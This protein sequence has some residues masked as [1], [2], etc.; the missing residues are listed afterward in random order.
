MHI[1][2]INSNNKA[3][4]AD[5]E[6]IDKSTGEYK[7]PMMRWPLR[8]AA[9]TNEIGEALRPIIGGYATL[10]WVPALMYIGADIYDKYK[11]DQTEYS[12]DSHRGL[13]QAIFQGMA[14]VALPLCAVKAGQG[15]I[16]YTTS[17]TGDKLSINMKEN[18]DN[19]A[20]QFVANG[21]MK[22][23]R[24]NPEECVEKF[25]AIVNDN[26][27]Y[28][29][30]ITNASNPIKK[31]FYK[32]KE[33]MF[34][35]INANTEQNVNDYAKNTISELINLKESLYEPKEH[36]KA[37]E[38][39]KMYENNM[40]NGQSKNVAIKSVLNKSILDK[41]SKGRLLKTVGGFIALGVAIRP[42]DKFVEEVLIGKVVA[43]GLENIKRP[44]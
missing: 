6:T 21:N 20:Q 32:F 10:S 8:G 22:R 31:G 19:L 11:N 23:Y 14:S 41:S 29:K 28:R 42:I 40:N 9:F 44:S 33:G 5:K 25:C 4:R 43:P 12:P 35:L 16:S 37:T 13:K 39:Y 15:I 7:D 2:P 27:D 36:F 18:V 34:K 38:Y 26:L 1:L 3:F 17:F 30:Q 24:H